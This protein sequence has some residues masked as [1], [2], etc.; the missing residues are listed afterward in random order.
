VR[1]ARGLI[2]VVGQHHVLVALG[3]AALDALVTGEVQV[4]RLLAHLGRVLHDP[5]EEVLALVGADVD[6]DHYED[7][8]G[9]PVPRRAR[10]SYRLGG[11]TA[12]LRN[13]RQLSR[14]LLY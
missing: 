12:R 11:A 13:R 3:G 6:P 14:E 9:P 1:L 5:G 8:G 7:H 2:D 4:P 10:H